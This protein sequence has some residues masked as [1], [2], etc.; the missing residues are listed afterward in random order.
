MD[1]N[2]PDKNDAQISLRE[3]NQ[4]NW[5]DITRLKVS[6]TQREFV[7]EPSYYLALCCYGGDWHPLAIC[8]DEQVIGFMMWAIDP[9]DGSC[10]LG[11]I[12]VDQSM[13][14]RGYG[15][16][17]VQAAMTM[18][19]GK[20]GHTNFALSYQPANH[21]AKHLYSKLG[22]VETAEWEGDEVV[23]RLSLIE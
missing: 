21:V 13:Q 22:F 18:L 5:R 2:V 23:A 15:K 17:A 9:A 8:F 3:V 1:T 7:A 12:L 16:L 6:E 19:K 4:D 11:G 20:H 14:K 10:W